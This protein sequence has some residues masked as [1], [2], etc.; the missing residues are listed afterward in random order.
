MG[1]SKLTSHSSKTCDT[2][3]MPGD[4]PISEPHLSLCVVLVHSD[5]GNE[6]GGARHCAVEDLVGEQAVL[7][8][9]GEA[10]DNAA[11]EILESFG[12]E[13]SMESFVTAVQFCISLLQ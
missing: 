12:G 2:V 1:V 9:E 10:L 13:A 11:S 7:A 3:C 8:G 6:E 5:G 4:Q